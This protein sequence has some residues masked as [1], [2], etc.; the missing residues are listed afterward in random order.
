MLAVPDAASGTALASFECRHQRCPAP[1]AILTRIK[2]FAAQGVGCNHAAIEVEVC[3]KAT[4]CS[5]ACR[6][7]GSDCLHVSGCGMVGAVTPAT[8]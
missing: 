4:A 6:D 8:A 7:G 5:A 1:C 3:S 2:A